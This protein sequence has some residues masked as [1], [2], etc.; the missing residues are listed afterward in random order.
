MMITA[1]VVSKKEYY[2]GETVIEFLKS[3]IISSGAIDTKHTSIILTF[4]DKI[5]ADQFK[6]GQDY[7]L[8]FCECERPIG[9]DISGK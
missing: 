4:D 9:G 2:T 1:K 8:N 7:V 3:P 5:F 6:N